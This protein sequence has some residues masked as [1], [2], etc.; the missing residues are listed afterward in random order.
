MG[1]DRY[2]EIQRVGSISWGWFRGSGG[3]GGVGSEQAAVSAVEGG[4]VGLSY[5]ILVGVGLVY[6]LYLPFL[7]SVG[8][9]V[10]ADDP[11]GDDS[12]LGDLLFGGVVGGA[13]AYSA[14]RWWAQ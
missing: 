6:G 9:R 12:F 1:T 3:L 8:D 10:P 5:W 11:S 7:A 13:L 4:F 2:E 14:E